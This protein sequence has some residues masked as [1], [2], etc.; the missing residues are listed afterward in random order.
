MN[1]QYLIHKLH[2]E[3]QETLLRVNGGCLVGKGF[4]PQLKL[5]SANW[6]ETVLRVTASVWVGSDL[7][8]R[9]TQQYEPYLC[10]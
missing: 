6:L 3:R 1:T 2:K 4:G 7:E 10:S 8:L 9:G 5:G